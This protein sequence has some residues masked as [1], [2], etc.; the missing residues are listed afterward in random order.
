M[1]TLEITLQRKYQEIWPVVALQE[2]PERLLPLRSEGRLQLDLPA[3]QRLSDPLEYGQALGQALFQ[4]ELHSALVRA[5]SEARQQEAGRLRILLE[6]EDESLRQVHWERLAAFI[7]ESWTS[8]GANQGTPFSMYLPTRTDRRFPPLSQRDLNALLLIASP[9]GLDEYDLAPF[10]ARATGSALVQALGKVPVSTL[11]TADGQLP[12]LDNLCEALTRQ[13]HTLLHLVCHGRYDETNGGET[14]LYLSNPAGGVAPVPGDE[15][16]RRLRALGGAHPLPYFV[17]LSTCDT[18]APRA[19]SGLGGLGQRLVR[20]LGIPAVVAMTGKVSIATAQALAERFYLRLVEHGELDRA[21]GEAASLVDRADVLMPALFS[22]LGGRPLFSDTL[23]RP[24]NPGELQN[25]LERLHSLLGQRAPILLDDHFTSQVAT[26]ERTLQLDPDSLSAEANRERQVALG[27]MNELCGEVLEISFAAL[28]QGRPVPEYDPNPP[29]RG[30]YPFRLEDHKYFFGR[31]SLVNAL[32]GRLNSHPFLAI[33]GP[34]GCGKSSLVYAGLLPALTGEHPELRCADFKPGA[35]PSPRLAASLDKLGA[36]SRASSPALLIVDQFEELFTLCESEA[37]RRTFIAELLALAGKYLVVLT[38]RAD[39]WGECAPYAELKEAM[40]AHQELVAPMD[41]AELRAAIEQQAASAGLRFEAG[42]STQILDDVRGEPGA[43]PLLQHALLLLWQNRHGRWLRRQEYQRFGGLAQAIAHTA[44]QVYEQLAA[45]QEALRELLLRLTRLD[46]EVGLGGERRDTRRRMPLDELAPSEAGLEQVRRL[47]ARLADERLLVTSS[48]PSSGAEQVEVAHEALIRSWPRLR[49]WL[50]EDRE[51][52]LLRDR[53]RREAQE[54]IEHRGDESYLALRGKRLLAS[55]ALLDHPRLRLNDDEQCYLRACQQ[56]ELRSRLLQLE[57]CLRVQPAEGEPLSIEL[58]LLPP[59]AETRLSGGRLFRRH[60]EIDPLAIQA[61]EG[62]PRA[63]GRK[64]AEYL[65]QDWPTRDRVDFI[66]RIETGLQRSP[67][68][69][70][71]ISL[72][73]ALQHLA[74]LPWQW[75]QIQE[76]CVAPELEGLPVYRSLRLN[77]PA[78]RLPALRSAS[79]LVAALESSDYPAVAWHV[80]AA[81]QALQVDPGQALRFNSAGALP[82]PCP[83]QTLQAR[84]AYLVCPARSYQDL[85]IWLGREIQTAQPENPRYPLLV[86][87]DLLPAAQAGLDPNKLRTGLY[88]NAMDVA[89]SGTMWVIVL[90]PGLREPA[91]QAFL[92]ALDQELGQTGEL[93]RAVERATDAAQAA[94]PGLDWLPLLYSAADQS[95]AWYQPGFRGEQ[96]SETYWPAILRSAQT[97]RITFILGTGLL[98]PLLGSQEA[99]AQALVEQIGDDVYDLQAGVSDLPRLAQAISLSSTRRILTQRYH[100]ALKQQIRHLHPLWPA[101]QDVDDMDIDQMLTLAWDRS[102]SRFGSDPYRLMRPVDPLQRIERVILPSHLSDPYRL[103]AALPVS[104]YLNAN[105]DDLLLAAL[106]DVGKEPVALLTPW[107]SGVQVVAETA[108]YDP[109]YLASPQRPLVV[110]LYGR[111][112]EPDS[113][114]LTEDDYLDFLT[115]L[116]RNLEQL[117]PQVRRALVDSSLAYLGFR[118][119]N[120]QF[121]S[122]SRFVA[123][124]QGERTR[125]RYAHLIQLE[126]APGAD[127][128]RYQRRMET[129]FEEN[130]MRVY[131]GSLEDFSLDFQERWLALVQDRP[132]WA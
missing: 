113:L 46:E 85:Q 76:F 50:D 8:L 11:S 60:I 93:D 100:R 31:D 121:Q 102:F 40:Q 32:R 3:L 67:K 2:R 127:L 10:D 70:L 48:D 95:A 27:A 65:F 131:W 82:D 69:R 41:A 120:R 21:L 112:S 44:E 58:E 53:L 9:S 77:V 79:W 29:F 25:G 7:D 37:L 63:C 110:S 20:E 5:L 75:L 18:A 86:V 72:A 80:P 23:A 66:T 97:S 105:P 24:L 51:A 17:Y 87:L 115:G 38:M 57:A 84:L 98:E 13:R 114:A 116:V 101:D 108:G 47:V 4:V 126:P 71:E 78:R 26:L 73:P 117:P 81:C 122:L 118:P 104:V 130:S 74:Y 94:H 56:S 15:L 59:G 132:A 99:I 68:I 1:T 83:P 107:K 62:N 14:I 49:A 6:V 88:A 28:A 39:F 92:S 45:E 129:Y 22:Q 61:L 90:P 106:R 124:L 111:L 96:A 16:I 109:A 36:A 91:L 54:W 42:L 19:E 103:L 30:L 34:S 89:K 128:R 35:D 64:L 119:E 125:A 12:T 33:L 123:S 52:L 55:A 43:M